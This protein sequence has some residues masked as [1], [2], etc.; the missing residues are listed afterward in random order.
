MARHVYW[1]RA[2]QAQIARQIERFQ[3]CH[4]QYRYRIDDVIVIEP[5]LTKC[6]ESL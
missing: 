3:I 6:G 5:Q 4:T 1:V 2:L